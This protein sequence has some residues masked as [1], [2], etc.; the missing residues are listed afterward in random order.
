[1]TKGLRFPVLAG[2][3]GA[4]LL[5]TSAHAGQ[6][7]QEAQGRAVVQARCAA[8]HAVTKT[9]ES[10]NPAAPPFRRLHETYPVADVISAISRYP[11]SW[12]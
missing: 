3:L 10:P 9:G 7:R 11:A 5:A 2:V 6:S 12:K 1:M 8:C 4:A